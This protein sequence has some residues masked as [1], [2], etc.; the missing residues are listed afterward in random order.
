MSIQISKN[1]ASCRLSSLWVWSSQWLLR[2]LLLLS[3][4]WFYSKLFM[5]LLVEIQQIII[6]FMIHQFIQIDMSNKLN[7]HVTVFYYMKI[8]YMYIQFIKQLIFKSTFCTPWTRWIHNLTFLIHSNSSFW[9]KIILL[10]CL[11]SNELHYIQIKI[12]MYLI[13]YECFEWNKKGSE[14]FLW[15]YANFKHW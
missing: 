15:V 3:R 9:S 11:F 6:W 8:I 4:Y 2:V 7:K 12:N 13:I 14:D 10:N 5:N 1:T